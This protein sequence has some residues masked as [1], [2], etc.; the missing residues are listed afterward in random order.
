MVT[1]AKGHFT[2]HLQN[3]PVG[4]SGPLFCKGG[5][6]MSDYQ[7]RSNNYRL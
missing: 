6:I 5:I 2:R 3:N 7:P 1:G 4:M